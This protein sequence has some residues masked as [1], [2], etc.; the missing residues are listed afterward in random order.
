MRCTRAQTSG[1]GDQGES[2]STNSTS[3]VP[4][5]MTASKLPSAYGRSS[6]S[7]TCHSIAP[8]PCS[9]A[10]SEKQIYMAMGISFTTLQVAIA[11]EVTLN[12]V[13]WTCRGVHRCSKRAVSAQGED[14]AHCNHCRYNFSGGHQK[15]A[16]GGRPLGCIHLHGELRCLYWTKTAWTA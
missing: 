8:M 11:I 15:S 3:I 6:M 14:L 5:S 12:I 9:R 1:R 16:P 7:A 13:S 2:L 4:F 10:L